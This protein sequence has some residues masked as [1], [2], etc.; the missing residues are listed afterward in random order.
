MRIRIFA[1]VRQISKNECACQKLQRN[2]SYL[3]VNSVQVAH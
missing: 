2:L 3:W 1:T